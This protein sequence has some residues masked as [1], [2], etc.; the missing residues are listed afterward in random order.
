M[1]MGLVCFDEAFNKLDIRST[2]ELIRL[3]RDLNLQIL[4]AAPEEKR[5]SFMEVAD[6]IVNISKTPGVP[7]LY[8]DVEKTGSR[9][10]TELRNANPEHTGFEGFRQRVSEGSL[11]KLKAEAAE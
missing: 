3:Y 6:T 8:I 1:G 11:G 10:K 7:E 4:I 5:T 2:Q 9:T